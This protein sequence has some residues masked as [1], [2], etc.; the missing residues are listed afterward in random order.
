MADVQVK[1][2]MKRPAASLPPNASLADAAR[3]M[4]ELD[5]DSLPIR[6]LDAER[7]EGVAFDRDIVTCCISQGKDPRTL[8]AGEAGSNGMLYC[9]SGDDVGTALKCMASQRV[10]RLFV[11]DNREDKRL[12]GVVE[13]DDVLDHGHL[14]RALRQLY[15]ERKPS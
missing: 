8:A 1:D 3:M 14:D 10:R 12:V 13:L 5:Y 6:A 11:L 7:L 4:D 15:G 9:F 2:I